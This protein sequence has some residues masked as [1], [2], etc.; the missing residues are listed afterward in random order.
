[1]NL[2]TV[3]LH[4]FGRFTDESWT[5]DQPLVVIHGPNELGKTTLRQAIMHGLLTSTD[6]TTKQ[7]GK[8]VER[9]IPQPGGDHARV[10]LTFEHGG[11][12]WKL[13]K[14]WGAGASSLLTDGTTVIGD[15]ANVQQKLAELLTH[16]EAT[17][18]HVL[19]TGQAELE[20]TLDA[21]EEN[22]GELRDI[23]DLLRIGAGAAGGVD[24][25]RLR[26]ELDEK[27]GKAFGRWDDGRG[28]PERQNGQEKGIANPW[29]NGKGHILNAWYAWQRGV[30]GRDD[31]L[32]LERN[33]DHVNQEV[34]QQE[35]IASESS[36]FLKQ[37]GHLRN[38]LNERGLLEERLVRLKSDALKLGDVYRGWPVANAAVDAWA[39]RKTELEKTRDDLQAELAN[40]EKRRD[41]EA[42]REAFTRVKTAK[43]AW[44]E[45]VAA[46]EKSPAPEKDQIDEVDRLSAAITATENKLA[47]RKLAWRIEAEKPGDVRVER[48]IEP[49]EAL[50]IG[51]DGAAGTAEARVR[52]VAGGIALTVKSGD[53]DVDDLFRTLGDNRAR[54][55]EVLAALNVQSRDELIVMAEKR[56]DADAVVKEKKAALTG[57]LGSKTFEQ[58][59]EAITALDDLPSTRDVKLVMTQLE[60]VRTQII[61]EGT[62]AKKH[63]TSLDAWTK[64][65]TD[66]DA[67]EEKL[68]T[69]K[70]ELK[71]QTERLQT[72]AT[73]PAG[74]DSPQALIAKLDE[75]QRSKDEAQEQLTSLKTHCAELTTT[76]GDRRSQDVAEAAE[77]AQRK[78]ERARA[79]G[80]AYQRIKQELDRI[81]ADAEADPLGPFGDK[82]AA[83]FSRITGMNSSLEFDG[84]MPTQVVRGSVSLPPDRLSH[85]GG[86]A[87]ALAVR[88]AMAEAYLANGGGFLMFDDPLVHFDPGRMAIATEILREASE[89]AQVIFFTCHDHHAER[90]TR[91]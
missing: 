83:L 33:I 37:Y 6:Q 11:S 46:A 77:V 35:Q 48:G 36:A 41:G 58:W 43:L 71:T 72:L 26:R 38:D 30:A 54:L 68:L 18:R 1:M 73:L 86:G 24:E 15:D 28:R 81:T 74:F 12:A 19:F 9:W 66:Q 85:G 52:V 50:T 70:A 53:D 31:V 55:A 23:R 80:R 4:P 13:V 32:E 63:Q 5:L 89:N 45:A 57:A 90:F 67:L 88:L 79:E 34:A 59:E 21:I 60:T 65:Y 2:K 75:S 27:I 42:T 76:L 20:Q 78:F 44:E 91:T 25:Q 51:P 22:S 14:R 87:L 39:T 64:A 61:T 16:N 10:T 40:A 49:A 17:F 84:Q 29:I 82:V 7:F 62:E 69:A 47:A 8:T 56:R 3:T